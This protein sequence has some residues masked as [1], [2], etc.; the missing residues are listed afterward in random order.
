MST[1]FFLRICLGSLPISRLREYRSKPSADFLP[2]VLANPR[3]SRLLSQLW[4]F[5]LY[6]DRHTRKSRMKSGDGFYVMLSAPK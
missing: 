1:F 2:S 5:G 4:V 6:P 3:S